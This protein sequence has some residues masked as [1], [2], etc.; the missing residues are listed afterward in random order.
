MYLAT[1]YSIVSHRS[2]TALPF[3]RR[4]PA[5]LHDGRSDLDPTEWK[6]EWQERHGSA[7]FRYLSQFHRSAPNLHPRRRPA[8]LN[9]SAT[10][11]LSL[12]Q[13]APSLTYTP[14]TSAASSE[15]S[16]ARTP[17]DLA[18]TLMQRPPTTA[19]ALAASATA[20]VDRV[21][22]R[23]SALPADRQVGERSAGRED[24]ASE[25][26]WLVEGR[27]HDPQAGS[28]TTLFRLEELRI[29]DET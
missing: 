27:D 17:D 24:P 12:A 5:V 3:G 19:P 21:G 16:V 14:A 13:T 7:A 20:T 6:P 25:K 18:A 29:T 9:R 2:R 15:G 22:G 10:S 4:I 26:P 11:A 28:L 23:G 8:L 1:N